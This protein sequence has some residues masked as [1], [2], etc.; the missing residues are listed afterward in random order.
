M[1]SRQ[2]HGVIVLGDL[3]LKSPTAAG[4]AGMTAAIAQREKLIGPNSTEPRAT[5]MIAR[6]LKYAK[7]SAAAHKSQLIGPS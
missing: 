1:P 4:K 3:I 6:M 5:Y 2:S 7:A